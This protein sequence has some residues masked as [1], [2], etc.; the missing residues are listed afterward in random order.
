MNASVKRHVNL[1][2]KFELLDVCIFIGIFILALLIVV[3][4]ISVLAT[5]LVTQ[6]EYLETPLLLIPQE[7]T[8]DNYF[9]LF[10]DGRIWI[11][12]RTTLIF[13]AIGVPF[14]LFL[15]TSLSYG[16]S[17][18]DFPGKKFVFYAIL[19]TMLF[20]G[21][22]VPLYLLMMQL[23]LTNTIWSVILAYGVNSFYM[24]IMRTY[25]STLPD[26]L[27]ESAK[28]DGAGEWRILFQIVLPLCMPIIATIILFYSVDRWNEW[29]NSMI[30]IRN[31]QII[32]L[33]LVLRNIVVD[34]Q[35]A[36]SLSISGPYVVR[37][38][39]GMKMSAVIV[40]M[41]PIM[42]FFPFLQKYFVKGIMIGAI[43]A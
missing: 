35:V 27:I 17:R 39:D 12:Y 4:F 42:C 30:F 29:F 23:K 7:P 13:L 11:G 15:T 22:I 18:P 9:R 38:A 40:T 6:K 14:N 37:F 24:I 3:P 5:S 25:M 34:S 28:L 36:A 19:V 21:G 41:L 20:N 43:K 10:Q 16:L 32:P 33:Q 31:N 8:V 2:Y 1:R 26:S